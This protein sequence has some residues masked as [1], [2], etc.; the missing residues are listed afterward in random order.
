MNTH[1]FLTN[2][3]TLTILALLNVSALGQNKSQT[4]LGDDESN[5]P[6]VELRLNVEKTDKQALQKPYKGKTLYLSSEVAFDSAHIAGAK[7]TM[8]P[9]G[10]HLVLNLNETAKENLT[11][12]TKSETG[13][14]LAL[15]VDGRVVSNPKIIAPLEEGWIIIPTSSLTLRETY[16]LA[17]DINETA[18]GGMLFLFAL[19]GPLKPEPN[20]LPGLYSINIQAWTEGNQNHGILYMHDDR[21]TV[22]TERNVTEDLDYNVA[23][24]FNVKARKKLED[25]LNNQQNAESF[26]KPSGPKKWEVL[27]RSSSGVGERIE[28]YFELSDPSELPEPLLELISGLNEIIPPEHALPQSL[29]LKS[30]VD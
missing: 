16:Q 7:W 17:K 23:L 1:P 24:K 13:N 9:N 5:T 26:K 12:L 29:E 15:L 30:P 19:S 4:P 18:Q 21:K 14:N 3:V 2:A 10:R 6:R 11:N 8:R 20:W 28:E 22:R 25:W 27:I